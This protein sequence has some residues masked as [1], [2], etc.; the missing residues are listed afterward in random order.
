MLDLK[1]YQKKTISEFEEY[2]IQAKRFEKDN[3]HK[4]AFFYL[5]PLPN[6]RPT[7]NDQGLGTPN[8]CIKIPTGGGKTLVACH[9]LHSICDKYEQEKNEKGFVM[10]LVPT[11]AIRTQTLN[12]LKNREHPYRESLDHYFSNNVKVFDFKEA[13]SIK[14]MDLQENLCILVA[15]FG[16]FRITDKVGRKAYADNGALIEHFQN[17]IDN[18]LDIDAE[19]Q[20]KYSL[21]NV[22]KLS[23]PI[24]IIDESHHTKTDLSFEMISNMNPTF[25]L[26][27]T[28]TPRKE[29]NVIVNI[30]AAE[31]KEEKMVKIP[32]Y[33]TNIA[34]WQET[35]R[36]GIAKR[37]ELEKITKR[38]KGEYIRPI[39]LIQAEQEREDPHKIYV[40]RIF[41]FL[42]SQ[43]IKKE[44]IAIKT[45][46]Q[47][48]ITG[49]NLFSKNC[50]IRYIITVSALKEGWDNSFA[51]VL[52]TVAN[53]GARI[54]VEQTIGRIIRLP[55]AREKR[56]KEL[57]FSYVFTSSVNFSNAAKEVEKGL[58]ANGYSRKDFK[59]LTDNEISKSNVYKQTISDNDIKIPYIA[60]DKKEPR[61]IEFFEDLVGTSFDLTAQQLPSHFGL[62]YDQDRTQ[63]IDVKGEDKFEGS[64]QTKL[65]IPYDLKDFT[66][67]DLLNWLDKKVLRKE[68]TQDEK[69]KF[70]EIVIN[71]LL[72][73]KKYNLSDLSK[74]CYKL[75]DVIELQI[76]DKEMTLAKQ[77]FLNLE[78]SKSLLL[79]SIFYEFQT[80][81]EIDNISD[82][83]FRQHLYEMSGNLNTEELELVLQDKSA[84]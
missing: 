64:R 55:N 26:E 42:V 81:V 57:N 21:M 1:N 66:K 37:N 30:T 31:L 32:I 11:D 83:K 63:V 50:P 14:K 75:K 13:L 24:I 27:Y 38:E 22:I 10:W 73:S 70:F 17:I 9:M 48:Q 20:V 25:V 71:S 60:I 28:A 78:K 52:I 61:P 15:T 4:I 6:E 53:I 84:R 16:A 2:L 35:I 72:E 54:V 62:Y 41:D 33:L 79:S 67:D 44:E 40:K 74:N 3:G 36:D 76:D 80:Q 18:N 49:I 45:G 46:V 19:G 51:Y 58:L 7:Y 69:R 39:A 65:N 47:D 56:N 29:S 43:G 12:N 59:Q 68:Y 5:N 77:N 34:Q 82:E 8:V 23:H